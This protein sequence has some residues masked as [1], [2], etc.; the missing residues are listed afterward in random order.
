MC[1]L[2]PYVLTQLSVAP[3][4]S[5]SLS[6]SLSPPPPPLSALFHL[7]PLGLLLKQASMEMDYSQITP[8]LEGDGVREKL[9]KLTEGATLL[10]EEEGGGGGGALQSLHQ[11]NAQK[12]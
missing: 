4:P 6:L 11:P 10:V 3:P 5:L 12:F 7:F 1:I 2:S 8:A 9:P